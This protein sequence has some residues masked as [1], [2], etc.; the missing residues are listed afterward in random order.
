MPF[1]KFK[2]TPIEDIDSSY[3]VY[4]LENFNLTPFVKQEM[5]NELIGRFSEVETFTTN[6]TSI[7]SIYRD[8]AKKYH[9]DKSEGNTKAMQAI[10]EFYELLKEI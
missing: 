10:N 9:P 3:I 6:K 4:C 1:G 7:K 5:T 8:L 2:G